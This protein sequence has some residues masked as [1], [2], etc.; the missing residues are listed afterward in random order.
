MIA[1]AMKSE[2]VYA[3]YPFEVATGRYH[4]VLGLG[5]PLGLGLHFALHLPKA[6]PYSRKWE[7]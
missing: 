2:I 4:L 5:S 1:C 6:R 3:A 7:R